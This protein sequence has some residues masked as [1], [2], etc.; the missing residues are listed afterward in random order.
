VKRRGGKSE[1]RNPKS[2]FELRASSEAEVLPA[3]RSEAEPWGSLRLSAR[4][5]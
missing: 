3:E 2:C 5:C 4:E 1:I